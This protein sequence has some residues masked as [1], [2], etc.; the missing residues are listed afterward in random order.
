[1]LIFLGQN[2]FTI[3]QLPRVTGIL[4]KYPA[5]NSSIA[6]IAS[7]ISWRLGPGFSNINRI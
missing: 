4:K 6:K 3:F 5:M 7:L 1:M 2:E